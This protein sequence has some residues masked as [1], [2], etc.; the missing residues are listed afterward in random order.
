MTIEFLK[1]K[2][3]EY[4][5]LKKEV[6]K[7]FGKKPHEGVNPDEVVALGAGYQAALKAQD[8]QLSE[9][10]KLQKMSKEKDNL[11]YKDQQK[12]NDFIQRQKQQDEMMKEFSEKMKE[13]LEQFKSDKKE[14]S[15]L[16]PL[17]SCSQAPKK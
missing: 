13:N 1:V 9:M 12:V 16:I 3:E 7:F 11:E 14:A 17:G 8:K 2:T 5:E 15:F 6:E 10:D 4:E